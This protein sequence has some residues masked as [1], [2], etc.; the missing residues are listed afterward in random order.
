MESLSEALK[1]SYLSDI[2]GSSTDYIRVSLLRAR[3][4]FASTRTFLLARSAVRRAT[5]RSSPSKPN[6]SIARRRTAI[7]QS[8]SLAIR[9]GTHKEDLLFHVQWRFV[10][11]SGSAVP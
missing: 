5:A 4:A 6:A 9:A 7:L 8:L 1:L 3:V 11:Y 10:Q 2:R